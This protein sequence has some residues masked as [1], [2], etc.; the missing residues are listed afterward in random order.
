MEERKA[1]NFLASYYRVFKKLPDDKSK[2]EF[3]SA[4]CEKQFNN[5]HPINLT[6]FAD[7]AYEGQRH[8]IEASRKGYEDV[9]KRSPKKGANTTPSVGGGKGG[10]TT[11]STTPRQQEKEQEKEKVKSI[12]DRKQEFASLLYPFVEKYGRDFINDFY[13]YWT[14][15]GAND[16]KMRFEKQTS[17]SVKRRLKTWEAN[18]HKFGTISVEKSKVEPV[19]HWN[20]E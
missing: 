19:K 10:K 7:L 3:I 6:D 2:A 12:K 9:Q 15:H 17:F 13:G 16:R 1:F 5:I 18:G 11:P 8:S 4:I 20:E 14:E